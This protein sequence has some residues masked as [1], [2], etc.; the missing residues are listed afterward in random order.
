MPNMDMD[1]YFENNKAFSESEWIDSSGRPVWNS[2]LDERAKWHVL[3]DGSTVEN[4][5]NVCELGPRGTGNPHLQRDQPQQ[6][7]DL[8]RTNH[9]GQSLLQP[10]TPHGGPGGCLDV[11]AFDE[12]AGFI[13]KQR[14]RPN[15]EGHGFDP[16]LEGGTHF[17]HVHGFIGNIDNVETLIKT[18][19]LLAPFP[20]VM[21]D[22][23]FFDRFHAYIPGWEIP[24]MRPELLTNQYG[25]I[26]DYLA[27]ACREMRKRTFGDAIDK[28]FRLGRDLN[29]RD[30]IA[31]RRT[32]SGLLK[33]LYP[34]EEYDRDAVQRCLEYAL[35]TRRRVKEQ[36]KKI[37]G[38]EFYDV[39]FSYTDI[40]TNE[41]RFVSVPEQGGGTYPRGTHEPWRL[42]HRGRGQR[43]PPWPVSTRDPGDA[44]ERNPQ[45]VWPGFQC[46]R[47]RIR[48]S[49]I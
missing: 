10:R 30:T 37:G 26:T 33:L 17:R 35:E 12:V 31:V 43:W 41:E 36:L 42:A 29:Q 6:H 40:E 49:W 16:S 23:A 38:M 34:H 8:R 4:N 5:Y 1:E 15:H 24:K 11:V 48:E 44:R 19:H 39:H 18:S 22:S 14:R 21:V 47:E 25:L 46:G 2:H 3:P 13:Q 9:R 20:E 28:Y 45:D 7:F 27:E 32:V